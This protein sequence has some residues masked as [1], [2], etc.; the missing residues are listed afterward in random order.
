VAD[1]SLNKPASSLPCTHFG[2]LIS[3]SK[4]LDKIRVL[5]MILYFQ[6]ALTQL[7]RIIINKIPFLSLFKNTALS[8]FNFDLN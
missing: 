3:F 6:Q 8:D 5:V 4:F 1:K 7:K 2:E